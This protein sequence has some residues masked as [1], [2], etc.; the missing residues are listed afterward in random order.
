MASLRF[1]PTVSSV[2]KHENAPTQELQ[3]LDGDAI[4][5]SVMT[6]AALICQIAL[7]LVLAFSP[8][9]LQA[10]DIN[11]PPILYDSTPV[12]DLVAQLQKRLDAGE[13]ELRWDEKHGWLPSLL[14]AFDIP[15]SS[16]LMVF[17]KTSFQ[18]NKISPHKPRVLYFNDEAYVGSVQQGEVL[19]VSTVD[20]RQG[21]IFYTLAQKQ[22]NS[23]KFQRDR[24]QCLACHHN[25]RTQ[26]VP[27]YLVRSVFPGS[28][29]N[30]FLKLGTTSTDHKTEFRERYG[31]WYVTGHHGAMRHRGN[32]I[33]RDDSEQPL[34]YE[35]GA[36]V[37]DLGPLLNTRPYLTPHS[38]LAALMVLEHQAQMHNYIT[39]AS[40]EARLANHYDKVWN[41]ILERPD[42]YQTDI[43]ARRIV[44]AGEKL[45]RY[46]LFSE[47]FQLTSPVQGTSD[48][49]R[50]FSSRG[51]RDSRGRSLRE[52]DLQTSLFKYPCSFLIYSE[53]FAALPPVMR[54]YVDRRLLEILRGE[55]QSPEFAH[56][57]TADRT[58]IREILSDT[59]PGFAEHLREAVKAPEGHVP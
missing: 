27:G 53:S 55:D 46:L 56:L 13:A 5:G 52:F 41:K 30:L 36:N 4:I 14:E 19:E 21:A 32:A 28:D 15:Q 50:E 43:S 22:T 49:T 57:T 18:F 38:D 24:N 31:G 40:Y 1:V 11:L 26:D 59:L 20:P 25:H 42:Y 44:S 10:D 9:A 16:Q 7:S 34:D 47:E 37:T 2:V 8:A 48:F 23:P 6:R 29:G 58:A 51:P 17:S 54:E 33:A 12:N 45:L 3:R 39:R 35:A